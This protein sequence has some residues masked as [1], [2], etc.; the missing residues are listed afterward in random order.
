M[1]TVQI[2]ANLLG[3]LTIYRGQE[4]LDFSGSTSARALLAFLLLNRAHPQSRNRLAGL[5]WPNMD[6][7]R[8]RRAL[9]QALWRI[10][11]LLPDHLTTDAHNV[12]IPVAPSLLIDVEEFESL[13]GAYSP[14]EIASQEEKLANTQTLCQAV[15]LYRGDLL[16]GLYEDWVL[17]ERERLRELFLRTLDGLIDLEK[18]RGDYARALD[19][20]LRLAQSDP[21]REAAHREV[22]RLYYALDRP[23]AALTQY[24][25]CCRILEEEFGLEVD[26]PTRALAQE[27][28]MRV[29]DAQVPYLPKIV[30]PIAPWSLDDSR[31]AQLPLIGRDDDRE[32][33]VHLLEDAIRGFGGL[34]LVEGEAGIGK[35]RLMTEIGRDAEWRGMQSLWGRNLE[36]DISSPYA[37][38]IEA[39]SS[40]L[41][42]LR[43]NQLSQLIEEIWFRVLLPLIPKL[44]DELKFLTPAPPLDPAQDHARLVQAFAKI[45]TAWGQITPLLIVVDDLHWSSEDS[46]DLLITLVSHLQSARIVLVGTYRREDAQIRNTLWDRLGLL[47]RSAGQQRIIL[48]RLTSHAAAEMIRR[49]LGVIEAVPLFEQ[50]LYKETQGNPLFILE[51]LRALHDEGLL[52]QDEVGNWHTPWDETTSD[53]KELPLPQAVERTIATRLSRLSDDEYTVLSAA[54]VLGRDFNFSLLSSTAGMEITQVLSIA[55]TLV[56]RRFLEE[57]PH[58]YQFSHD[59]IRQVSYEVI[60]QQDRQRL[61]R[62][63]GD[64]LQALQ[65]DQLDQLE[66]LAHHFYEAQAWD[67]AATYNRRAG[68]RAR[69]LFANIEASMYFSRALDAL[70]NIPDEAHFNSQFELHIAREA[71]YALLGERE[72]Q[73]TDLVA[74]DALLENPKVATPERRLIVALCWTAYWEAISDYPSALDAVCRAAEQAKLSGDKQSEQQAYLKWGQMLC[75]HGEYTQSRQ[76][77]ETAYQLSVEIQSPLAQAI[78]LNALGVVFFNSGKYDATIEYSLRALDVGQ[79]T[80][81]QTMLANIHSNL[82]GVYHYMADFPAAIEHYLHALDLRRS[83]GDRRFE[84]SSLYNLAITYSDSGDLVAAR[85]NLEQVCDITRDIGDRR[86]EG[87]GWVFLGLVLEEMGELEDARDAYLK[88]LALRREVGLHAMA[89]D[90]LA[91]LARVATAEGKHNEAIEYA[92]Q[93]LDWIEEQGYEGIGDPLLAYVGAYRALLKAGETEKGIAALQDAYTLLMEFADNISDPEQRRAYLHD[94]DPGRSIWNDYQQYIVGE[95]AQREQVCLARAEAPMGRALQDEEFITITWTLK[96][97]QDGDVEGKSARRQHRLLRLM[98]EAKTHGAAP[99]VDDLASALKVSDRTIKRDLAALR[100]AGR[101]VETRG[102]A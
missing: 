17:V 36:G 55:N 59:K 53:Y 42:S 6:E 89:N 79:P 68:D 25:T 69:L 72:A 87:Y 51:T 38:I 10:R 92:H 102:S 83:I 86:V 90:P 71:V 9:T 100:N 2:R 1:S 73:K 96:S 32:A 54:A 75:H 78:S 31:P 62:Q 14:F 74:L 29:P 21:Y 56:R 65:A 64:S 94:I 35:T 40:G 70:A 26:K 5:F 91:G 95:T 33:I 66:M 76:H 22:M 13:A 28:A 41:T 57:T 4:Q 77:L 80:D 58:A 52:S 81:D 43:I 50:R 11:N 101:D 3:T 8:S 47:A 67:L 97:P 18:T 99:T 16:D 20:A 45:L 85:Q 23:E 44:K 48:K 46:I 60:H 15:E 34:V 24:E 98:E 88:G 39:L 49:S 84:A 37:A 61:H 12:H 82:G 30:S 7:T 19:Y 27:I 63:A 93:V